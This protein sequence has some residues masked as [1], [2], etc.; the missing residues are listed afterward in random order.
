ME[1]ESLTYNYLD[2]IDEIKKLWWLHDSFW[3][4]SLVR[5]FD[6]E[7]ANRIN[8]ETSERLFR[9]LTMMLLKKGIIT[10]PESIQGL[11]NIFK[12][13]WK[14]CFFDDMYITDPIT[15]EGNSATWIGSEC[16][17]YDSITKAGM[18]EDYAC[19]C[20]AIR[21]GVMKALRLK[22]L[23]SIEESLVKGDGRCVIKL[24]FE[25][26]SPR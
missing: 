9:M 11:M 14:T 8:L 15:Y 7:T 17:A 18:A 1:T 10:K 22:P 20:Q 19:G 23:H 6:P 25:L 3:H 4:A 12:T 24:F 13:I 16:N 2:D 26:S 21:N 5:E